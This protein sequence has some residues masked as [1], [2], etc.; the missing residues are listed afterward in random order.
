MKSSRFDNFLALVS[1][2]KHSVGNSAEL[3]LIANERN[4]LCYRAKG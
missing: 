2:C 4:P 3:E 1:G